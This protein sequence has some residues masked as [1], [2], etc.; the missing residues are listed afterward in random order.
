[1]DLAVSLATGTKFLNAFAW[2]KA[3]NVAVF[4]G[5]SGRQAINETIQRICRSKG[6]EPEE[7]AL[8]CGFTL[9][10]LGSVSDRNEPRHHIRDDGIEVVVVHPLYLCL[11][12]DRLV[13]AS[14]LF[15]VGPVLA[16]F[17]H[18]CRRAGATAIFCSPHEQ[19]RQR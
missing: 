14:N 12:G 10:R 5:E 17:G 9:P 19:S 8:F 13:A 3:C 16:K 1:M 15:E 7:C 4:S 18:A 6:E 2:P 11:G